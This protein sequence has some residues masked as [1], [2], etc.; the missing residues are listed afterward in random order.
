MECT[1]NSCSC[2][3]HRGFTHQVGDKWKKECNSCS[4]N[5]GGKVE[6]TDIQC[7]KSCRDHN[8]FTHQVGD[9]WK[10]ECNTCSCNY[11]GKVECSK[12]LCNKS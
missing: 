6:C 12:I 7:N 11:G 4:C 1:S 9:K 10:K 5:Y 3:D 2:K 8:G